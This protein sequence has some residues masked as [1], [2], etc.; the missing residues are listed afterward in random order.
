[1]YLQLTC[2]RICAFRRALPTNAHEHRWQIK[3]VLQPYV[4]TMS[5]TTVAEGQSVKP[6]TDQA[7]LA[8]V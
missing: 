8:H 1:M 4:L 7:V 6:M 5:Q 3:L 2:H